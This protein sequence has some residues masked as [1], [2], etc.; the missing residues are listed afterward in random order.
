M[1]KLFADLR[2]A[3]RGLRQAPIFAITATLTLALGIGGTTAIFSLIHAVMLRSLPVADPA[4]LYRIGEGTDCCV[5]GSPQDDWGLVSFSLFQRL[6][7]AAPEFEQ[8]TAFQAVAPQLSV[9]RAATERIARPMRGE[10][11]SGNYFS[12]FGIGPF[13]GR[14][15]SRADD[16]PSAAPVAVLSY[17]AWQGVYGADPSVIGSTFVIESHPFTICG[18][19][20]PGFFGETLRSDPADVWLPLAQEPLVHGDH[21]LLNTAASAWLRVI[22]RL[23]PGATIAGLAPRFTAILRQWLMHE[24]GYPAA[25]L[26]EIQRVLPKQHINVVPAG[27]GVAIM[28]A[29]YARS[30]SILLTVCSL[31]LLIACANVA[32]LLLARAMARRSQTSVRLALGASPSQIMRQSLTESVVLG[33]CGG[34]I[35][36]YIAD[37]AGRLMLGLAFHSAHFVPIDV[38]PSGPVLVFAFGLSLATGILFGAAPAWFATRTDPVE[39]LRGANRSTG[40]R[41]SLPQKALLIVQATLAVVL[42][43]GAGMLARSLSNLKNQNFGIEAQRRIVVHFNAPPATYTPDRLDALYRNLEERLNALPNVER[44]SLAMYNPFANNWSEGIVIEGRPAPHI[45]ENSD[46]SWDRVSPGYF[47]TLG[48]PVIRGRSFNEA[49]SRNSASVAI[50]NQA[51]V[52]KFFPHEDP[53]DRHFGIDLPAE[54]GRF[55]IIGVVRDAKYAFPQDPVHPMFFIPSGQRATYSDPDMARLETSSHFFEGA[56]LVTRRTPGDLEP[57]LRRIFSEADPNLTI[58]SVRTMQEHLALNFDQERAV[59]DL[60]GL[61]GIVALIL[62]AVGLY[63]VTAYTV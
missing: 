11:V 48:Q 44:A 59:A 41:S 39:A 63:G 60:A 3:L 50:V 22:G 24:S 36:L 10:F 7:A 49:D 4:R 28:Q 19:A 55:R 53:L 30:L 43:A 13:A 47:E 26:P 2:Y 21:A 61:F 35:G 51:F 32:N 1:L 57:A 62:A 8:I 27:S 37:F 34:L 15:L 45:E 38:T 17:R 20:P 29:V 46:A 58:T 16:R 5:M 33:V 25:F 18:I 23:R 14:V 6:K 56:V 54:A 12:T 31:V 42:V 9:R 52:R 40:D